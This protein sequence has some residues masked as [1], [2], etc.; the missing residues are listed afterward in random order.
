MAAF[1]RASHEP[2]NAFRV[3]ETFVFKHFFE[4]GEVFGRLK[5]YY[6]NHQ[7][8]FEV[9]P[10]EFEDVRAFLADHGYGLVV[11]D[12]PEPFVVVVRKYTA[13][14]DNIFKDSVLQR[15]VKDYNCFLMTDR[16]AVD[17]A[18]EEG[19]IRIAETDIENPV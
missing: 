2:V 8:R 1:R 17:R 6:N 14:P 13:H 19:A 9:P 11:I 12:D 7:Y 15:S 16:E 3:D 10:A 5:R 18:V 4:G